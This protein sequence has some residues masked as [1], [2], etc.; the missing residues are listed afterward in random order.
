MFAANPAKY[1]DTMEA[2]LSY[3]RALTKHDVPENTV[4]SIGYVY[5]QFAILNRDA[6]DIGILEKEPGTLWGI[7]FPDLPGCIAAAPTSAEVIEQAPDAVAQWIEVNR[8]DGQVVP[9]PRPFEDLRDDAWVAEA[10]AKGHV[11]I[12]IPVPSAELGLDDS[13]LQAVDKA[14]EKR[15]LSRV[16]FLRETVLEK[17]AG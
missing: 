16:E 10:L 14:A 11:P 15:G 8:S 17:I 6:Y 7:W 9:A 3:T 2:Q 4:V 5:P 13:I 1:R 12:V